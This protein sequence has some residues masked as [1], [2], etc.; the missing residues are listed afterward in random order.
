MM[1]VH[2][3]NELLKQFCICS[4]LVY[5]HLLK[6]CDDISSWLSDKCNIILNDFNKLFCFEHFKSN[7]KANVLNCFLLNA[8]FSVF[9]HRC[10]NKKPTIESFLHSMRLVKSNKY[11]I[12]KHT[13]TLDKDHFK[14]ARV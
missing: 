1:W 4:V 13:G 9:R 6:F 10:S 8:R 14:W 3:A 2:F 11:V 5:T 7:A 12:A